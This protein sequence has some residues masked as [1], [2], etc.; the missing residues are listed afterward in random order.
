[1]CDCLDINGTTKEFKICDAHQKFLNKLKEGFKTLTKG[2]LEERAWLAWR[3]IIMEM[4][5]KRNFKQRYE[6]NLIELFVELLS[7]TPLIE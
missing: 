2:Q 3:T 7:S 1:M 6:E 5:G 4:V